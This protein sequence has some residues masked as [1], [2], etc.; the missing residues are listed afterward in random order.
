MFFT[1][2]FSIVD[3]PTPR[4][5][6]VHVMQWYLSVFHAGRRSSVAKKPYNPV[7]GEIFR[8][9]YE[10]HDDGL[11]KVFSTSWLRWQ[12]GCYIFYVRAYV[13]EFVLCSTFYEPNKPGNAVRLE[14][15]LKLIKSIRA[16]GWSYVFMVGVLG[17]NIRTWYV[18]EIVFSFWTW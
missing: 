6:F 4:D 18:T 17:Q 5:R 12:T 11:E 9:Y 2:A 1:H 14:S 7:L 3:E 13:I 10:L 15:C 8:C 16:S